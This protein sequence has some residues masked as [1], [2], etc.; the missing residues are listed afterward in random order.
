[1]ESG[2][3][4]APH[5]NAPIAELSKEHA[6]ISTYRPDPVSNGIRADLVRPRCE[7]GHL[8]GLHE[9][10]SLVD[11]KAF[12]MQSEKIAVHVHATR[13]DISREDV[14]ALRPEL[15]LDLVTNSRPDPLVRAT[16]VMPRRQHLVDEALFPRHFAPQRLVNGE[17]THARH[18]VGSQG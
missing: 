8:H 11:P 14:K 17:A 13:S 9:T 6:V 16:A 15:V 1:M 5:K 12:T 10:H 18:R 3:V 2:I 4:R 7:V